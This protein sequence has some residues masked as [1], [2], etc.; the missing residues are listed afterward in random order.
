MNKSMWFTAILIVVVFFTMFSK[1]VGQIE[2]KYFPVGEG[3]MV[4]YADSTSDGVIVRGSNLRIRECAVKNIEIFIGRDIN[5][6]IPVGYKWIIPSQMNVGIQMFEMLL[7]MDIKQL[8][9]NNLHV[10][11]T[12]DCNPFWDTITNHTFTEE[13]LHL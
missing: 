1:V 4:E 8:R 5:N 9:P 3:Y 12:H 6:L 2:G 13:Y 10:R 11:L 7:Y